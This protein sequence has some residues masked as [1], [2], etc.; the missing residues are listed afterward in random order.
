MAWAAKLDQEESRRLTGTLSCRRHRRKQ[1]VERAR[2]AG[3]TSAPS[4]I[5]RRRVFFVHVNEILH[6]HR[7]HCNMHTHID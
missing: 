5:A 7:T 4:R 3:V 1:K 6:K 2:Q